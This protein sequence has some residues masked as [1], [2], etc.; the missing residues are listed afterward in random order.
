VPDAFSPIVNAHFRC[1]APPGSPLFVGVVDGA[2]QWI[3][4]K[5]GVL[6]VTVSAADP[7]ID[8]P[9]DALRE[10]LWH[11]VALA[12]RLPALPVPPAR[13]VKERRATFL[14]SPQQLRRRPG[15]TTR[16]QQLLLAGDY[17][18]TGLPATIEGAIGSGFAAARGA[19]ARGDAKPRSAAGGGNIVTETTTGT[20]KEPQRILS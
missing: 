14:A 6:S 18:D 1:S 8:L 15:V 3:F 20:D 5:H 19:L 9:A 2:A 16:W 7:V 13:I 4:R 10:M 11:D 12:Y 17:T